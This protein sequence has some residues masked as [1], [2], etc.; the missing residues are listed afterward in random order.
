MTQLNE[1]RPLTR[2]TELSENE[3]EN[4]PYNLDP[5]PSSSDSSSEKLLSDFSSKNKAHV[6]KKNVINTGKMTRQTHLQATILTHP[7]TVIID[8]SDIKRRA[9]KKSIQSNYAHV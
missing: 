9:I 1:N 2:P 7:M 8:A 3:K 5:E 4:V 6:K